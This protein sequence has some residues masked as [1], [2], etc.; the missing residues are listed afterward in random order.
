M[1]K[2]LID[3]NRGFEK[4]KRVSQPTFRLPLSMAH[5][6]RQL[7]AK[8]AV[9]RRAT[10]ELPAGYVLSEVSVPKKIDDLDPVHLEG[11][12][13]IY[14]RRNADWLKPGQCFVVSN[15]S[16]G[17]LIGGRAWRQHASTSDLIGGLNNPSMDFGADVRV[18]IHARLLQPFLD[19]T[20]LFLGLP[21]VLARESRNV[22]VAAGSCV[23]VVTIFFV[24]SIATQ[25]LGMNYLL[26]PAQAAWVPLM[27]FVP[28]AVAASTPLRR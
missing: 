28:W 14:T 25:S 13:V 4:T 21:I 24:V 1:T 11:R 19:I 22:F 26:S 16:F 9:R 2:I 20:L 15:V 10:P 18:A 12:P 3:G 23:V 8:S 6:S 7:I 17:Q 27:I 5:F